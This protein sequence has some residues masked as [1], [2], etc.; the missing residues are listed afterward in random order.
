VGC[1]ESEQAQE[2]PSGKTEQEAIA[3]SD[4]LQQTLT[5][6]YF[7]VHCVVFS[8]AGKRIVSGSTDKTIK[9]WDVGA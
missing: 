6:H 4:Q 9:I 1:G 3:A 2:Q 8:P 5:G 7:A